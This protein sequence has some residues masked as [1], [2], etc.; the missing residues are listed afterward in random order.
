MAPES[1]SDLVVLNLRFET[2]ELK[3]ER[4]KANF[5]GFERTKEMKDRDELIYVSWSADRPP[6]GYVPA[7]EGAVYVRGTPEPRF[8]SYSVDI[9]SANDPRY[10]WIYAFKGALMIVLL[11]PK[12]YVLP[13]RGNYPVR[14]KV[15]KNGRL[16]AY[17]IFEGP[18]VELHWRMKKVETEAEVASN[19]A[20]INS[21]A[22][23]RGTR[24]TA[25][26]VLDPK[27]ARNEMAS[28]VFGG[29]ALLFLMALIF[30]GPRDLAPNYQ[31]IVPFIAAIA[32]GFLSY[33]FVGK[34]DLSGTIPRF[35]SVRIAAAGGF[36][37]F[38]FVFMMW[39]WF[40]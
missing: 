36:A 28:L 18:D 16:A 2:D 1:P 24:R 32:G 13:D 22:I 31:P 25:P 3:G 39:L 35:D 27:P 19:E 11:L 10:T 34:L 20:D 6:N 40:R 15:L 12:N 9:G 21:R 8:E 23:S 38:V 14:A 33:F 5:E 37:V 26:V 4:L 29:I 17:W 30:V 7:G